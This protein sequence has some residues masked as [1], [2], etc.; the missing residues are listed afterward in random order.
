MDITKIRRKQNQVG[1]DSGWS[2]SENHCD[3]FRICGGVALPWKGSPGFVVLVAEAARNLRS[4]GPPTFYGLQ[5][6][7]ATTD[8]E[9]LLKCLE[10]SSIV[11]T[12][13]GNIIP[14]AQRFAVHQF[15]AKRGQR[16]LKGVQLQNAP[17]LTEAGDCEQLFRYAESE[18]HKSMLGGQKTF[19]LGE[20]PQVQAAL[21]NLPE[22]WDSSEKILGLPA[23]TALYYVLG[24]MFCYPSSVRTNKPAFALT[25]YDPLEGARKQTQNQV[26]TDYDP[27]E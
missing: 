26:K 21:Q 15:N 27:F 25:D 22:K 13:Y 12:W 14:D 24:A 6:A 20:C 7:R 17:M 11:D 3:Y 23:V 2:D 9:L 5:E 18:L 16:R 1:A 19:F 8:D 4:G 10:L